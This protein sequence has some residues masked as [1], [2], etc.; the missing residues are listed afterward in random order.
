MLD[1][2]IVEN[3]DPVG[4]RQCFGLIVC[5]VNGCDAEIVGKVRDLELHVFAKL[6]VQRTKRFIH[7]N[8]LW[9]EHKGAG[10]RDTLLLTA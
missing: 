9:L 5:H 2:T 7:Q 10:Q 4:H 3:R 1:A 6:L 8:K